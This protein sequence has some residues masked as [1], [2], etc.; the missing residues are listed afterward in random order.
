MLG[1]APDRMWE[2][3]EHAESAC[4]YLNNNIVYLG[5]N[6]ILQLFQ[7]EDSSQQEKKPSKGPESKASF[8]AALLTTE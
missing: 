8:A 4:I 2:Q 3:T 5:V 6:C 7:V 1:L